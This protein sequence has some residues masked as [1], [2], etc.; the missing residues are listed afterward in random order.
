MKMLTWYF[1]IKTEFLL[2]MGKQ[3][4]YMRSGIGEGVWLKL[5]RA[6]SDSSHN[7]I[8][9]SLI[10]MDVVVQGGRIIYSQ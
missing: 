10:T 3:G 5:E 2:S 9:N 6:Y 1:G 7:H 4:K 8:W